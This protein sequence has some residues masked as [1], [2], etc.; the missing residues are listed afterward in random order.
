MSIDIETLKNYISDLEEQT[1]PL[2]KTSVKSKAVDAAE[3]VQKPK[4]TYTVTDKKREQLVMARE[5]KTANDVLRGKAKKLESAKLLLENELKQPKQELPP[6]PAK[7]QPV[8]EEEEEEVIYM[9]IPKSKPKPKRKQIII[10]QDDDSSSSDESEVVQIKSKSFGKSHKNRKS[11]VKV[12][13]TNK[14][15]NQLPP[16]RPFVNYFCD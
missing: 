5:K 10:Q 11:V 1:T 16:L 15:D 7:E 2:T 4:K 13:S 12:H 14:D 3:P 6:K 8:A 9:K